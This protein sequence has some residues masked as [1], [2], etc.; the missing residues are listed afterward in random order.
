[1]VLVCW[2]LS[3]WDN[4]STLSRKIGN[5]AKTSRKVGLPVKANSL[6]E[7]ST[8]FYIR[9]AR[10]ISRFNPDKSNDKYSAPVLT[11][12]SRFNYYPS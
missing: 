6:T 1:M 8:F 5:T 11:G 4:T 7:Q 12:I 2:S 3:Y 10:M 9:Y